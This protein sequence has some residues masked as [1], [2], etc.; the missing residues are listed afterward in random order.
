MRFEVS[1]VVRA[2]R[3]R[4]YSAY[5][6][7]E[8]APR[9]SRKKR[10][11]KIARKEADTVYLE[12]PGAAAGRAMREMKLFPQARVESE[13]ETRFTRTKSVVT[14]EEAAGGTKVTASLDVQV[15]GHWGWLVKTQGR[16][17]VESSAMEDLTAFANYV[18][19]LAST[20]ANMVGS[21]D[22]EFHK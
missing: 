17:E 14:F 1:L 18:E 21:T 15:K 12:T 3:D 2:P 8:A 13:G 10:A 16:A 7:F 19:A 22:N 20:P 11:I 5:T 6:D 4:V 9:W